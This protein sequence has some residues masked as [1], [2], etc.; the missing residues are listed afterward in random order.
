MKPSVV[1]DVQQVGDKQQQLRRAA[2]RSVAELRSLMDL[3]GTADSLRAVGLS[4]ALQQVQDYR[5]HLGRLDRL[6]EARPRG[7]GKV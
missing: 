3:A 1:V 6:Q 4:I 2:D 7:K 5:D